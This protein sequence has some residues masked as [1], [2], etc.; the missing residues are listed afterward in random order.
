[1][2][3]EFMDL[4]QR[5][6]DLNAQITA[7]FPALVAARTTHG[8][9]PSPENSEA[10][11]R[12]EEE[13]A[14]LHAEGTKLVGELPAASGLPIEL[15]EAAL[16]EGEQPSGP[17]QMLRESLTSET[18]ESTVDIDSLLPEALEH[19]ESLL[20]AGWLDE[21][22]RDAVR[23]DDLL[24]AD[25]FLSLTKGVRLV[26]ENSPVHRFRQALHVSRDYLEGH[27]H[28]DH[29]AGAL[30]VPTIVQ[31]ARQGSLIGEVG[32]QRDE[33]LRALWH[34]VSAQVDKTVFE[35]FTAAACVEMGR[36]VV[37]LKATDEASPDLRCHDPYPSVIE[38]KRQAIV[39]D[40]EVK[41]EAAMQEVFLA[42]RETALR[43]GVCGT[44][45]LTLSEEAEAIDVGDVIAKLIGQ[46]LAPDPSRDRDYPWGT[47]SLHPSHSV[48]HLPAA[49]RIYSPN[50]LEY[51][52]GWTFDLPQW[53][54]ICCSVT[55]DG[56]ATVEKVRSPI[57]LVWKNVSKNALRKRTW[58]PNNL[59]G[60]ASGQIPAGEFGMIYVCYN[61][62]TRPEVAN[63]RMDAFNQRIREFSHSAKVRIPI[64]VLNR[65]Y[66]RP[67]GEGKPDLIESGVRYVA[68]AYADGVLFEWFPTTVF[69]S[70]EAS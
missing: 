31:L 8:S 27:P 16:K 43:R 56:S 54:G 26:S 3:K 4:S 44:F 41:E 33:R 47:V 34:G 10:L 64:A 35:L 59:F 1:M 20:P 17:H 19:V 2:R 66:P 14:A 7:K 5:I 67:L 65:L 70:A 45:H 36:K 9:N 52:F 63:M 23:I 60:Q 11:K 15:F 30:L 57:A 40:Y 38:C 37:F 25:A 48:V 18:V 46:R 68:D 29:F 42:L 32:G 6:N 61:E 62:G 58:A 39:S 55:G 51:L 22:P 13:V 50:M 21:Q 49:T 12:I 28:Y 24:R 69:T 53:D